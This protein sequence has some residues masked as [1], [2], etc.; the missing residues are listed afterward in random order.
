MNLLRRV[1]LGIVSLSGNLAEGRYS[2]CL[3]VDT[4]DRELV[5]RLGRQIGQIPDV[6]GVQTGTGDRRA[7]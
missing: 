7:A 5:E 1:D 6:D 3:T 4:S 2:L